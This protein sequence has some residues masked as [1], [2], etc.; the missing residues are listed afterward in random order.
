[1]KRNGRKDRDELGEHQARKQVAPVLGLG[2][3]WF[4]HPSDSSSRLLPKRVVDLELMV[5]LK[6]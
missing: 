5:G 2:L 6:L 3:S 1:M 4:P